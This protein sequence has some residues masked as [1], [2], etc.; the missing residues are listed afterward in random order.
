MCVIMNT[1]HL[2]ITHGKKH[3]NEIRKMGGKETDE[4]TTTHSQKQRKPFVIHRSNHNA[5]NIN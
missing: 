2:Q 4:E 5:R 1:M 3:N